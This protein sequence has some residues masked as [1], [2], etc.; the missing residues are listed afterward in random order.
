MSWVTFSSFVALSE[1]LYVKFSA[2][3]EVSWLGINP[4]GAKYFKMVAVYINSNKYGFVGWLRHAN[5][6]ISYLFGCRSSLYQMFKSLSTFCLYQKRL[7]ETMLF[8][9][10]KAYWEN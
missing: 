8:W 3:L 7:L 2:S 5:E 10:S 1:M 6:K 4:A 9:R